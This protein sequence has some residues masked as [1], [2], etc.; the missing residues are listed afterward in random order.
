M[1][2]LI[3]TMGRAAL[4]S[5]IVSG[6]GKKISNITKPG[7]ED[8][9][10]KIPLKDKINKISDKIKNIKDSDK[11]N[12]F[13]NNSSKETIKDL[14]IGSQ[15]I[16]KNFGPGT[17]KYLIYFIFFLNISCIFLFA[18][19]KTVFYKENNKEINI[20]LNTTIFY[21]YTFILFLII[22]QIYLLNDNYDNILKNITN[23]QIF[24]E[25]FNIISLIGLSYY[26]Y[27]QIGL[28]NSD[29]SEPNRKVCVANTVNGNPNEINDCVN[30]PFKCANASISNY[31]FNDCSSYNNINKLP[32]VDGID[33]ICRNKIFENFYLKLPPERENCSDIQDS[34]NFCRDSNYPVFVPDRM[35]VGEEC[36]TYDCCQAEPDP[37]TGL[38]IDSYRANIFALFTEF[39]QQDREDIEDLQEKYANLTPGGSIPGPPGPEGPAGPPG[40]P[41]SDNR[42]NTASLNQQPFQCS[43]GTPCARGKC[44]DDGR[45]VENFAL[46]SLEEKINLQN[47]YKDL[48]NNSYK[49]RNLMNNLE[50]YLLNTFK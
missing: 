46:I 13:S 4:A 21:I 17:Y 3:Y 33:P 28:I 34:E 44:D 32:D 29:C 40:I 35:C 41:G 27:Y 6:V 20:R 25:I 30:G 36:T 47:K 2:S 49:A 8:K 9:I 16:I 7:G 1:A 11:Y 19:N 48:N 23:Y 14:N 10:N 42:N 31:R 45:C 24:F 12:D 5:D 37:N 15:N 39:D 22:F 18:F 43:D 26:I 38:P 50:Q